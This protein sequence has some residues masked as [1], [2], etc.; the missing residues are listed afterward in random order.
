[1]DPAAEEGLNAWPEDDRILRRIR[2]ELRMHYPAIRQAQDG[3]VMRL[4]GIDTQWPT[5]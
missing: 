3:E 4:V 1:M 2:E 5:C